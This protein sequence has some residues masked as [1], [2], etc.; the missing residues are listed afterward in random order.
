MTPYIGRFAPSP[1]GPLHLGSLYTAV[2]SYLD[3]KANQGLWLLRI[4][5]LDPPR[6]DP[7]AKQA[8]INSLQRHGLHW[9]G[10]I[11]YQSQHSQAYEE[12]LQ[13]LTAH[14]FACACSRRQLA[15]QNGLHSGQ[16]PTPAAHQ[17]QAL[18]LLCHEQ[19]ICFDDAHYG[20]IQQSISQYGDIILKRKEGL[21]AY[22]LAAVVDDQASDISHIVR[23]QDLLDCSIPQIYLQQHLRYRQPH[24]R[25]LPL[26]KS[27][28]GQKL[29]KQ[30]H[31]LALDDSNS[32]KNLLLVLG[33][34]RQA[35]PPPAQ[36]TDCRSILNW[37][38]QHWQPDAITRQDIHLG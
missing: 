18:R 28:Q 23:G 20:Q 10:Q 33:F 32:E 12:A 6:E 36:Q 25:H 16:C 9:D 13:K 27:A 29:S 26:I 2:A 24:Y 38:I 35:L 8:I 19:A 5:D 34:L 21:Y 22:H 31:A 17:P 14:T 3:A 11:S 1:T 4:D 37:A 30:N 7:N 15:A